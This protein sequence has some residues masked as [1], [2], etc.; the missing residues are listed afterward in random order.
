MANVRFASLMITPEFFVLTAL[1]VRIL[2]VG[3]ESVSQ[4]V[5]MRSL[6]GIRLD[7]RSGAARDALKRLAEIL[8]S[9]PRAR[10]LL[11]ARD[12]SEEQDK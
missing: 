11:D 2:D 9:R 12:A 4:N 1:T 8:L 5:R 6:P 3:T 10:Q 7:T